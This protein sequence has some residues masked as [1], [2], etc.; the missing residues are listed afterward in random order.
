MSITKIIN[1]F[2]IIIVLL[3]C[4]VFAGKKIV[5][6][7]DYPNI[8]DGLNEA[9]EGDTIYVLDGV[10]KEN[11]VMPDAIVLQGQSAARTILRGNQRDPVVKAANHSMISNF[12]IKQG[13]I[14]ILSENTNLHIQNCV[15]KNNVKTG[16][17]CLLSLP[18]IQNN[19]ILDN[20]W[21]GVFCELV[22]YGTRT[23]IEH[24]IFAFNNYSGINLS[25]KSGVLIQ[26]N[27]FFKNK[28]FG[29][30]V[31][32]DSRKS[33]I[34]Y[35]DFFQNRRS[36]NNYAVIDATNISANPKF[37]RKAWEN[38]DL[39]FSTK[40]EIVYDN[41]LKKMGKNKAPIGIVSV[42]GMKKLF[43]DSDEDGIAEDVDKC[44]ELAEDFDNFED[45]DGC[46]EYDNDGDGIYDSK[47]GCPEKAE[48]FDGYVDRDGCPDPDNDNDKVPDTE[49][50]CPNT[51]ETV[52]GFKDEDGCP[53]EKPKE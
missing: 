1:S 49:D 23:A 18:Y 53:D 25:R 45:K 16:I 10:Y 36:Y 29:I 4:S 50:K 37:P 3:I 15:I 35:N 22:A 27:V 52:N 44:P 14:G 34:I 19:L 6:P 48:D 2:L 11:I 46:P 7:I 47:D 20:Q 5:I 41:P 12:T 31:S 13:G 30:Y 42:S 43:K 24:N 28:Q 9:K 40:K 26:N 32:R 17:H 33:R 8:Q 21:S 39:F 51:P 38:S